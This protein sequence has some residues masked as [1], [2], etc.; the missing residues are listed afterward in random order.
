MKTRRSNALVLALSLLLVVTLACSVGGAKKAS[1]EPPAPPENTPTSAPTIPAEETPA[2]EALPEQATPTTKPT[3]SPDTPTPEP[4]TKE[5]PAAEPTPETEE[6]APESTEAAGPASY[7]T[8]FPLPDDVQEFLTMGDGQINYQT[9]LSM[10]E[11]IEFYRQSFADMGL[12]ER[13]ILTVID[14]SGFSLVFDGW[15]NGKSVVLQGVDFDTSINVNL[16]FE[17]V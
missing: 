1:E 13:P 12:T 10:D 11:I 15:E 8:V 9:S 2:E 7:D 5:E 17:D 16:R 6:P 14:D 3:L 4:T